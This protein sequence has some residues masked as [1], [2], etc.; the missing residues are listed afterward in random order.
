MDD[1]VAGDVTGNASKDGTHPYLAFKCHSSGINNESEL[2]VMEAIRKAYP[3]HQITPA[4]E[5]DFDIF[6]WTKAGHAELKS[7]Q[8]DNLFLFR[9]KHRFPREK[10]NGTDELYNRDIFGHYQLEFQEHT[11]KMYVVEWAWTVI[12]KKI[13]LFYLITPE[14]LSKLVDDLLLIVA[15]WTSR[16]HNEVY[17]FDDGDW[18][19]D[20]NLWTAM[21][22]SVWDDMILDASMKEDLIQDV[23]GFFDSKSLY[24]RYSIPWKRGIIFHGPPGCGK[25]MAIRTLMNSLSEHSNAISNL[26]A[27]SFRSCKDPEFGIQCIF[28]HA[29]E[30]TPCLLVF[31]DLDSLV[32]N[33]V[34]SYFLNQVDGIESN[35]GILVIASTNH[36]DRL[37]PSISS[38]PSRFDKKYHFDFPNNAARLQ[39]CE[40]WRLKLQENDDL[41]FDPQVSEI[42]ATLTDGFSFAYLKELLTQSLF[43]MLRCGANNVE[44]A[45]EM[46][47][48][49]LTALGD[50]SMADVVLDSPFARL[51]YQQAIILREDI[52]EGEE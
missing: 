29:R 35:E 22:S 32:T 21:K 36:V 38:R 16:L 45:D 12:G 14:G 48:V 34:R 52:K 33:D 17:V 20:A 42:I 24:S 2:V 27:K 5:Q 7:F 13:R 9:R 37:D 41:I 31:E 30:M 43:L 47:E 11:I 18:K 23:V 46:R 28:E 4:A 39:Y 25:T 1:Q 50:A 6:G 49:C 19:K 40:Y 51:L 10:S 26:V 8:R 44:R 15:R 3:R